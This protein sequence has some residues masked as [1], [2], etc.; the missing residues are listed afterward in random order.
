M[1][2][3]LRMQATGVSLCAGLLAFSLGATTLSFPTSARAQA[4]GG[5]AAAC[6]GDCGGDSQVTVNEL[7][8]MV[9]IA[10]GTAQLSACPVGDANG[11]GDITVNEIISAV[12][13]ALNGCITTGVCGDGHT[14]SGEECDDGGICIGGDNAGTPCTSD[15]TCQ[16]QGSC[17]DGPNA[18]RACNGNSDCP[19]STCVHCRPFGGDG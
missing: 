6:V 4:D 12:N 3:S 16:G 13:N 9:N 7:I 17:F 14:D 2:T 18:S 10:L 8:T 19:G 1:L 11:D 5:A 15:A